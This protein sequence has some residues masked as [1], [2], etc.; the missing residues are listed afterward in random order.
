MSLA[1]GI[2]VF[3][4]IC[5]S[6]VKKSSYYFCLRR[7]MVSRYQ[8]EMALSEFSRIKLKVLA[9]RKMISWAAQKQ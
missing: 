6:R 4:L 8:K 7:R 3:I 2:T 5:L 9:N 1:V